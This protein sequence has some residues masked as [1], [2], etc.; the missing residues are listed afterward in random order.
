MLPKL[1]VGDLTLAIR[2]TAERVIVYMSTIRNFVINHMQRDLKIAVSE[3]RSTVISS[4]PSIAVVISE[5]VEPCIVKP[6]FHAKLLGADTVG[7]SRRCTL[8]HQT[9]LAVLRVKERAVHALRDA[10]A[11]VQQ[12]VRAVPPPAILYYVETISLS[13]TEGNVNAKN[14]KGIP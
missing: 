5:A 8:Q 10:G 3:K 12:M 4:Q 13:D 2:D 9:R 11:N 7:G 14:G 6:T 1:Y